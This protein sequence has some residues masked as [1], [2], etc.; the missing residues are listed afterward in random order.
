MTERIHKH[1]GLYETFVDNGQRFTYQSWIRLSLQVKTLVI[2]EM[3][4]NVTLV[5]RVQQV[6][7]QTWIKG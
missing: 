5:E 3:L 1:I 6:R 2:P 7:N 4:T